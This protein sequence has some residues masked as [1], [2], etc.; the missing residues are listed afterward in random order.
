MN[1]YEKIQTAKVEL[2]KADLKKSGQNKYAGYTYFEL[3]DFLPKINE[4]FAELQLLSKVSFNSEVATLDI[5]DSEKPED[6]VTFTSP[7]AS[8]QLKGC[9]EIQNLGAVQT[10][11]RRY[12]YTMALDIA[13]SDALEANTG[14]HEPEKSVTPPAPKVSA[15]KVVAIKNLA[16][17][18]GVDV[19]ALLKYYNVTKFDDMNESQWN[20]GMKVLQSK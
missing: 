14:K 6:V 18:K 7:M 8:A 20:H 16:E 12:L 13:E 17:V 1:I 10:Y 4:I 11:Q 3:K 19:P 2:Q 5:V 15:E 9:H